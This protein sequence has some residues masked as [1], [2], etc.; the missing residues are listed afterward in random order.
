MQRGILPLFSVQASH[1]ASLPF[2]TNLQGRGHGD[3]QCHRDLRIAPLALSFLGTMTIISP[4]LLGAD[5]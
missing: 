4:L 2:T 5:P 1:P 3:I